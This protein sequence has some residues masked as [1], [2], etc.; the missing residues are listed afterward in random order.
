[1]IT[2]APSMAIVVSRSPNRRTA[3]SIVSMG[4][5]PRATE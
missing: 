2:N 3:N 5:V 4:P 1:M